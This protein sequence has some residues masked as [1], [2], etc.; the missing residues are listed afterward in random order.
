M[1]MRNV[2][3]INSNVSE[4]IWVFIGITKWGRERF[5][6]MRRQ[7][8]VSRAVK[9]MTQRGFCKYEKER[10]DLFLGHID[11]TR[12]SQKVMGGI[13]EKIWVKVSCRVEMS[14]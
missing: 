2:K 5:G 9:R 3:N 10:A 4:E 6:V 13:C 1:R 8:A 11:M 7:R 14:K 12:K